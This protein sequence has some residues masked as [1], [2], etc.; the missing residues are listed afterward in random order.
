MSET[1]KRQLNASC[2]LPV[3]RSVAAIQG[4]AAFCCDSDLDKLLQLRLL[5][6][7]NLLIKYLHVAANA[8]CANL[9]SATILPLAPK[10]SAP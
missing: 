6:L 4:V 2:H 9:F 1:K 3:R 8:Y 5:L 7:F 10:A